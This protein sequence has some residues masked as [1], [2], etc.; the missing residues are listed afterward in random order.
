LVRSI[1]PIYLADKIKAP[2]FV[3][4]GRDDIR[5]PLEQT[6]RMVDA[7]TR[8]GNPPKTV[9]IKAEEGHGFGKLENNVDL[10]TQM[11][12]FLDEHLLGKK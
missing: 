5:T 6:R 8:A 12:K 9:L 2:L 4:A 11:L 3:Y 7:L 10:Y 1:S